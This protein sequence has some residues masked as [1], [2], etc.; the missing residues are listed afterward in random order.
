MYKCEI[1]LFLLSFSVSCVTNYDQTGPDPW[2]DNSNDVP[3]LNDDV[4]P[5][6]RYVPK[7][8]ASKENNFGIGD[9]FFRRM[10]GIVLKGGQ[11]KE[12][13]DGSIDVIL[14]MK[15]DA[16]RWA[17]LQNILKPETVITETNLRRSMSYVEDAVYKS[18][19]LDNIKMAWSDYIQC[20][21][22]EYKTQI[23]WVLGSLGATTLF[24]WLWMHISHK[25]VVII[26]FVMVYVYEVFISY[27]EAEQ[28]EVQQF[29]SALET[30]KW[31]FW[32]SE[33]DIPSPDL[34]VFMKHMNPLKI[35]LRMFTSI[36]SEPMVALSGTV[37]TM[38][39][40]ITDGLW[41]PFD[42]IV[43]GLLIVSFNA[44]LMV[45]LVMVIFNFILNTPFN[46]SFGLLS[47]GVKQR[48]RIFPTQ[49]SNA[50]QVQQIGSSNNV[51][52]ATLDKLLDVVSRALGSGVERPNIHNNEHRPRI[53]SRGAEEPV[54]RR[55]ASTGRLPNMSFEEKRFSEPATSGF[56]RKCDKF[57][58]GTIDGSGD[59]HRKK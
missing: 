1:V 45:L 35:A 22:V 18:T 33:C 31:Q 26:I 21:L 50:E 25:H 38:V 11:L 47:I 42:A 7:K 16:K 20:Y 4:P 32:K 24:I 37:K 59:A 9:I 51:S 30:C 56:K 54:I 14:Q 34:I 53:M 40:G 39:A 17:S 57:T 44:L 5:D 8:H 48:N 2:D 43:Y 55:S 52:G 46:L 27:K 58:I 10:L 29:L 3:D 23:T 15:F 6:L 36:V 49:R 28:K 13:T 12:N 19:L 41:P